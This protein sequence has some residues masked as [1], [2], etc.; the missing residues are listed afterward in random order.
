MSK[1]IKIRQKNSSNEYDVL[2]PQ[3][4]ADIVM[5]SEET[6]AAYSLTNGTAEDAIESLSELLTAQRKI[7]LKI[8][9]V[10]GN[11][12]EGAT[13]SGLVGSPVTDVN[14]YVT[15]IVQNNVVT[16]YPPSKYPDLKS[17]SVNV[18]SYIGKLAIHTIPIPVVSNNTIIRYT[19][20]SQIRFSAGTKSIDVCCVG[21]G[22]GGGGYHYD[23][24][25]KVE[26]GGGG[27]GGGIV[28]MYNIPIA[29]HTDYTITIGSGG[30]AASTDVGGDGGSSSFG[31]IVIA[32]GG[33]GGT[34]TSG[35]ASGSPTSGTGGYKSDGT[36]SNIVTE[37]DDSIT[38]YSG[39]GGGGK[40][41]S[42]ETSGSVYKGGS[43]NGASGALHLKNSQTQAGT[44]GIGGGGG[45][46]V[47][48]YKFD[49]S[50]HSQLITI[51]PSAGGAGLVAIRIHTDY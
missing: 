44:A 22:G 40:E 19:E 2:Y 1:N 33:S 37:F 32:N 36:A 13:V 23:G 28:N 6:S 15:G 46:G 8:T 30:N 3:S 45:G 12:I 27:G 25:F 41:A 11:P 50:G 5:L 34:P 17:T 47:Y 7:S 10:S 42:T 21:A 43:P 39:G 24:E 51:L 35:G 26:V 20:S 48:A 31:N 29:H 38:F 14:G 16:I 49:I 18:S 9:D 4:A